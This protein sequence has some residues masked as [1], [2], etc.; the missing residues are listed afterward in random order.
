LFCIFKF[1]VVL[2]NFI[3]DKQT[4]LING[5]CTKMFWNN[6]KKQVKEFNQINKRNINEP[7]I[8]Q[9]EHISSMDYTVDD[10]GDLSDEPGDDNLFDNVREQFEHIIDTQDVEIEFDSHDEAERNVGEPLYLNSPNSVIEFSMAITALARDK[11]LTD[12]AVDGILN[13]FR[14]MLPESNKVPSS[15]QKVKAIVKENSKSDL[16]KEIT[17]ICSGCLKE[18]CTCGKLDKTIF[19]KFDIQYQIEELLKRYQ[20]IMDEFRNKML[21]EANI[22]DIHQSQYYRE[23]LQ[24]FPTMFPLSLYTDGGRYTK[25]GAY[26]GW[27]IAAFALDLPPKLRHSYCNIILLGYWYG[28]SKPDWSYIFKEIGP[29]LD[30]VCNGRRHKVKYLQLIADIPARQSLLS[31]IAVNGYNCCYNCDIKGQHI[32]HIVFPYSETNPRNPETFLNFAKDV[33]GVTGH[34]VLYEKLERF[35]Q[36]VTIDLMHSVFRGPFEDD[37]KRLLKGFRRDPSQR[38]LIRLSAANVAIFDSLISK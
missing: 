20:T 36:G 17:V 24:R 15:N 25:T 26:E 21:S 34:S 19:I 3:Y 30:F 10:Y 29:N 7:D 38:L 14:V 5:F 33:N 6:V 13:L 27:P 9:D 8:A 32:G 4:K 1:N 23:L 28:K 37:F 11:N 16:T 22:M 31:M 12:S 35:P 2:G 18:C